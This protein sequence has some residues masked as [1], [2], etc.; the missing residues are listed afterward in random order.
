ME[1]LRIHWNSG[2]LVWAAC[3]VPRLQVQVLQSEGP[4]DRSISQT[5][6][7]RLV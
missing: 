5:R 6:E 4:G 7:A 3:R 2:L 1:L